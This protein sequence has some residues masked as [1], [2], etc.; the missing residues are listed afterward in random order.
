VFN[1]VINLGRRFAGWPTV[2]LVT[3]VVVARSLPAVR[4][5]KLENC[6]KCFRFG[7]QG[8]QLASITRFSDHR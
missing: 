4:C 3:L 2:L 5:G 7:Q 8:F 1:E 6:R